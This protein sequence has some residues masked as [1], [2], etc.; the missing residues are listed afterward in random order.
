VLARASSNLAVIQS[1]SQV[2]EDEMDRAYS[3]NEEKRNAYRILWERQ[4]EI[5]Y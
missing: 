2:K 1:V 4:N 5:D 3:M